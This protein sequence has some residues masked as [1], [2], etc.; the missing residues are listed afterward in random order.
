[1]VFVRE[2][3][4]SL[5]KASYLDQLLCLLVLLSDSVDTGRAWL[6][7]EHGLQ[8]RTQSKPYTQA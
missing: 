4:L 5:G 6:S 1:M 7:T 2:H 8:T 3:F